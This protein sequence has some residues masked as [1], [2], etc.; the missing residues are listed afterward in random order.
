MVLL[1]QHIDP[2][3]LVAA[4][5]AGIDPSLG[6]LIEDCELFGR[7]DR[8]PG[9]QDQPEWR[10]FDPLGAGREI[11][12]EEQRRDRGLVALRIEMVLGRGKDIE[13]G[14][15]GK[16]ASLRNSSSIR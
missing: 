4:G 2:A 11:G 3:V 10:E 16:T 13:A 6:Q 7:S 15:V 1:S 8:V 5:E 9:W 14:I 12:I